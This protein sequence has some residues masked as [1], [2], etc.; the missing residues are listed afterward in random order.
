MKV[1][2]NPHCVWCDDEGNEGV[3]G[4]VGIT[5]SHSSIHFWPEHYMFDLYSCK[6]FAVETVV[7]MLKEFNT[8]SLQYQVIDRDTGVMLDEG[9][10]S[11][12][13]ELV[14]A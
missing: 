3:T 13:P 1:L 5:T 6:E 2:M 7:D 4:V 11:F 10:L 9:F 12:E 8:H 14:L